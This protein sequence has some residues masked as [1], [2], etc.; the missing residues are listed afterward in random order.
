MKQV[1][2]VGHRLLVQLKD[3]DQMTKGGLKLYS[4]SDQE[5]RT[6]GMQIAVVKKLGSQAFKEF[7]D[8]TNWCEEGDTIFMKKYAGEDVVDE[9]TGEYLRIINDEE[10][11]AIVKE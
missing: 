6:L 3:S 1:I 8:G 11:I 9:E 10:V 5:R 4:D 2:P 7:F